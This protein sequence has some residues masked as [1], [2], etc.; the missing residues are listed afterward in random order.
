M[1]YCKS[2]KNSGSSLLYKFCDADDTNV[3]QLLHNPFKTKVKS[4][5]SSSQINKGLTGAE[6]QGYAQKSE[7]KTTV[8]SVFIL[9]QSLWQTQVLEKF[10]KEF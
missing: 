9:C 8:I 6:N 1:F 3:E 7:I 5:F 4:S 10:L 2:V